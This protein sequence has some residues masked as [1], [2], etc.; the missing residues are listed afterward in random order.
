MPVPRSRWAMAATPGAGGGTGRGR[1]D[2]H[3][4]QGAEHGALARGTGRG[5][6][7]VPDVR[8]VRTGHPSDGD[9][10]VDR[11]R[12]ALLQ[13]LEPDLAGFGTH[14][15]VVAARRSARACHRLLDRVSHTPSNTCRSAASCS[16]LRLVKMRSSG[17]CPGERVLDLVHDRVRRHDEQR[18]GA[19][20]DLVAHLV[21][22]PVVDADVGEGPGQRT[23]RGPDGGTEQR[24]EEDQAEQQTPEGSTEGAG[25]GRRCQ[26]LGL[27]LLLAL[28]PRDG[29]GVVER[30]DV[31]P[32]EVPE[33][34]CCLFGALRAC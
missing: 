23:G 7:K 11:E 1:Q 3:A 13:C 29:G 9:G 14:R 5:M 6:T 8:L 20:S 12:T 33:S 15:G 27:G 2:Q 10:V 22:E 28:L 4:H 30:D 25:L 16:S 31:L 17:S 19:R 26:L 21:D 18:R 32:G 24:D 34:Q